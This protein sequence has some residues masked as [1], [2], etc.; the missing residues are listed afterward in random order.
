VEKVRLEVY[1]LQIN[2]FKSKPLHPTQAI[3]KEQKDKALMEIA[4]IVNYELLAELLTYGK[5][6]KVLS[7]SSLKKK[8]KGLIQDMSDLYT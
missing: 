4:V 8:I 2:Y 1:G 3:I 6:V 7:P 5:Q